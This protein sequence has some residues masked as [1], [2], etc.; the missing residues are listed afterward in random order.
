MNR[1]KCIGAGVLVVVVA[2]IAGAI[3]YL[4]ANVTDSTSFPI[5]AAAFTLAAGIVGAAGIWTHSW[6]KN[7][8]TV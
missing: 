3:L 6:I 8:W 2:M 7:E 4:V 5:R 1:L